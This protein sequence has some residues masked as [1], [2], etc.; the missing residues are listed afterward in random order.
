MSQVIPFIRKC[1]KE[2]SKDD[3][4]ITDYSYKNIKHFIVDL[5]RMNSTSIDDK[6]KEE[7]EKALNLISNI[8][9]SDLSNNEEENIKKERITKLLS[10]NNKKIDILH[11]S[12]NQKAIL[13]KKHSATLNLRKKIIILI[14]KEIEKNI[15]DKNKKFDNDSLFDEENFQRLITFSKSFVKEFIADYR[16]KKLL[17]YK[18]YIFDDIIVNYQSFNKKRLSDLNDYLLDFIEIYKLY[19]HFSPIFNL[20]EKI[21]NNLKTESMIQDNCMDIEKD[22]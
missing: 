13:M 7:N 12:R 8:F 6:K 14:Q 9:M 21:N 17:E 15:F 20:I 18:S 11:Y 5:F 22:F 4:D 3:D 19:N 1:I 2:R 16:L 10:Y